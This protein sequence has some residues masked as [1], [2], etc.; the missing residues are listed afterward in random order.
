MLVVGCLRC[1]LAPYSTEGDAFGFISKTWLA[2]GLE[3][4]GRPCPF[5]S[6]DRVT[7]KVFDERDPEFGALV[8]LERVSAKPYKDGL[9][10]FQALDFKQVGAYRHHLQAPAPSSASRSS[11]RHRERAAMK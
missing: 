7:V 11:Q 4:D 2:V 6:S 3:V 1:P 5:T 10:Y 9:H 8:I